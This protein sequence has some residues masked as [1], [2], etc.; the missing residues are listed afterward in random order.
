M[1]R[2]L[3]PV[4]AGAVFLISP[5]ADLAFAENDAAEVISKYCKDRND[6]GLSHGACVAFLTSA[7]IVPHNAYVCKIPSIRNSLGVENEGQCVK[8]LQDLSP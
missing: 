3:I 7:N 5:A 1:K 4:L 8:V 2:L 6:L